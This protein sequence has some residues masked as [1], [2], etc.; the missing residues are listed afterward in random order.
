M[1]KTMGVGWLAAL[2]AAA[3][4]IA[5][6]AAVAQAPAKKSGPAASTST[7]SVSASS[8]MTGCLQADGSKFVLTNLEGTSAPK[9]RNWKTGYVKKT[10]KNVEVVG[11][12]STLKLKDQVGH[13]VTVSGTKDGE[14]H[15]K[16]FPT[17][18]K[19]LRYVVQEL[20]RGA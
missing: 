7:K 18:L 4:A 3:L 2:G 17:G 20:G 5:P 19:V 1:T 16:A 13:K 8:T 6:I 9:G 12:S 11:A 10:T 14:T 15:F